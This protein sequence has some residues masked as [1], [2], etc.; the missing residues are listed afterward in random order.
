MSQPVVWTSQ[1]K[2]ISLSV[3]PPT[4]P[5]PVSFPPYPNK[6]CFS[7]KSAQPLMFLHK[8]KTVLTSRLCGHQHV[9]L[10]TTEHKM[11]D[12]FR[13]THSKE[14]AHNLAHINMQVKISTRT[15]KRWSFISHLLNQK[16][17]IHHHLPA[18]IWLFGRSG[19]PRWVPNC[20]NKLLVKHVSNAQASSG[21]PSPHQSSQSVKGSVTQEVLQ[22]QGQ[23]QDNILEIKTGQCTSRE[24]RWHN[25]DLNGL[26]F[27]F[28]WPMRPLK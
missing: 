19:F 18:L 17:S 9:C 5:T 25:R 22:I 20:L 11:F 28:R 24:L 14:S 8:A 6:S 12:L 10:Q 26:F 7:G 21:N 13:I 3:P 1:C 27:F 23:N 4:H 2:A 15:S 16:G